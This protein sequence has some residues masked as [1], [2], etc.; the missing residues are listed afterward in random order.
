ML[1]PAEESRR[2]CQG[3]RCAVV[4]LLLLCTTLAMPAQQLAVTVDDLPST[5]PL[6][7]GMTRL[8]IATSMLQ[9]LKQ[10]NMP[11]VYGMVNGVR[12]QDDPKTMEVLKAWRAA[13][14]PL[15]SHTWS[16]PALNDISVTD[17]T[18][19]IEKNE[20]LLSSLMDGQDWHWFRYPFLWEGDTLEK[21]HAVRAYLQS[22]GYRVAQVTMDF[23]DYL[24]NEPYARCVAHHDEHMIAWLETSYLETAAEYARVYRAMAKTLFGREIPYVLLLHIG[25][26]SAH[27][28][29]RLLTQYR[30]EGFRFVSLETAEADLAYAEDPD[31]PLTQGGALT[32]Q[33]FAKR[34]LKI[35]TNSKPYTQLEAAC[36]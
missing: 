6:P 8:G 14:E 18:R 34:N 33:I 21:R 11:P 30:S 19:E 9:T 1:D 22:H 23:E 3:H 26:F 15:G 31:L 25:A 2:S 29:P 16:H 10:D 35:P 27:M 4:L 20:A 24:W 28:L 12:V 5:G 7:K 13:G 32:E 17:F 36:R